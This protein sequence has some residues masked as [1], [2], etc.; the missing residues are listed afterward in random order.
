[1]NDTRIFRKINTVETKIIANSINTISTGLSPILDNL[2]NL[3]YILINKS[4][5]EKDYPSIYLITNEQQKIVDEKNIINQIY[6]AG[7]YFGF[8]KKGDFYFS[9]EGVEYIYKNGIFTNFKHLF[10]NASG[11]KSFLYG[12]NILKKMVRKSPN[13]L[14]EKDFLLILNKFDET[15]GIG[16]SRVNNDTISNLK[17]NNV[18]AINISD[19]GQ[20]LRRRQ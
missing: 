10:L 6:A 7:L 19:K 13:S 14:K 5:T 1:M 12:N 18:F 9:L 15:I 17:P 11:E 2:K 4:T 3:L 20:Y 16:I 8:I